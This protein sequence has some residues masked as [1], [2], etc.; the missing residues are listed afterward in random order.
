MGDNLVP[1]RLS[2]VAGFL[3]QFE[4][5]QIIMHEADE[6]KAVVEFLDAGGPDD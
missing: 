1:K 2:G 3:L 5:S 4:V 6:P